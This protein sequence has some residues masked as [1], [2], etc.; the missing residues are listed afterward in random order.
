MG[1]TEIAASVGTLLAFV[2]IALVVAV[3]AFRQQMARLN[4]PDDANS[5]DELVDKRVDRRVTAATIDLTQR[6]SDQDEMIKK[7]SEEHGAIVSKLRAEIEALRADLARAHDLLHAKDQA[8]QRLGEANTAMQKTLE[9][10][11]DRL[12]RT[13][14]ALDNLR[15]DNIEKIKELANRDA[16][17]QRMEAEI[18]QLQ[19]R[20]TEL[21]A[22][23]QGVLN[24]PIEVR[25]M[26]D[27]I[28][29]LKTGQA[30]PNDN[31]A[32]KPAPAKPKPKSIGETADD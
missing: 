12:N 26:L 4:M 6:I 9:G 27:D 24:K 17:V 8:I 28:E 20:L 1:L 7:M 31:D 16:A 14:E 10:L 11:Q 23:L 15:R 22:I 30:S 18:E 3:K 19:D 21:Q 2:A 5:I 29:K 25:F 32:P 13:D